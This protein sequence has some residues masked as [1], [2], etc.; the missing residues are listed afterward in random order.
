MQDSLVYAVITN[1]NGLADTTECVQSVLKSTYNNLSIVIVDNGSSDGS[2]E[3]LAER[4]PTVHQVHTGYSGAV[5]A[6]YNAGIQ[7][8]LDH[9]ADYVLM[10]NNDTTVDPHMVTHLVQAANSDTTRGVLTPKIYYYDRP[11]VICFA[12]ARCYRWDFGAYDTKDG[13]TDA[14]ANSM[15]KEIDYVWACGMLL[16]RSLLNAIGPFDTRFWLY[17]DD[18]DICLRARTTGYKLWY[19]PDAR[20][21]H[22]VSASTRSPRF[23]RTWARSKML[24]FRKHASGPH[25]WLLI[26][27]AFGHALYRAVFPR[28]HGGIRGHLGPFMRGL[29]DGL[30]W[31]ESA[32]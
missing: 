16:S 27:Y 8:A 18:A 1:W 20:M 11:D 9:N 28:R 7:Y 12:G 30:V 17:Y 4:F 14:P 5:T 10:L 2:A 25:Q 22:K 32:E 24:L 19:V 31:K 26:M 29:W 3:A 6:A 21:W 23:A 13:Q 15:A